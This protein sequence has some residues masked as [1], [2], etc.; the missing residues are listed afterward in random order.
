MFVASLGYRDRN[1]TSTRRRDPRTCVH[2]CKKWVTILPNLGNWDVKSR[3]V[4]VDGVE[5]T[6]KT[7]GVLEPAGALSAGDHGHSGRNPE[8]A[9]GVY[10]G[11]RIRV[12]APV[13][14]DALNGCKQ[15]RRGERS[16]RVTRC[17]CGRAVTGSRVTGHWSL[18]TGHWSPIA[19]TTR[20]MRVWTCHP[21]EMSAECLPPLFTQTRST[22]GRTRDPICQTPVTS[23][24]DSFGYSHPI[25]IVHRYFQPHISTPKGS[26]ATTNILHYL[27]PS[28]LPHFTRIFSPLLT[29]TLMKTRAKNK[30]A[31]PA[32]PVMTP[33]Q[34]A[35]AGISQPKRSRRQPTKDQ[36]IAALEEDLRA[37]RELLQVVKGYSSFVVISLIHK[38]RVEPPYWDTWQH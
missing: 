12:D 9:M 8:L 7:A 36:R 20:G 22:H 19:V 32:A 23:I 2:T 21:L 27:S 4:C 26:L 31:H 37:T 34:L 3:V 10:L 28:S 30:S 11:Q 16:S 13:H 15:G 17:Y 25:A 6:F 33:A 1:P 14:M 24:Q 29:C 18:V 35:A 38:F 5:M